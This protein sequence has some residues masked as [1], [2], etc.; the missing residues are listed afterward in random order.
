MTNFLLLP[1]FAFSI[2]SHAS[3]W[4]KLSEDNI[5]TLYVDTDRIVKREKEVVY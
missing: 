2:T 3:G 1:I 5:Q 4:V